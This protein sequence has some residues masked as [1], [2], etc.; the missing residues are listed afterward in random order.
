MHIQITMSY[1]FRAIKFSKVLNSDNITCGESGEPQHRLTA[2]CHIW[3][4]GGKIGLMT[5]D[6]NFAILSKVKMYIISTQQAHF[7]I[8]TQARFLHIGVGHMY[9]RLC[10][11]AFIV[12]VI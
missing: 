11:A 12:M 8:H 5:R 3:S 2:I 4:V 9:L 6:N 10:N 1:D 7:H